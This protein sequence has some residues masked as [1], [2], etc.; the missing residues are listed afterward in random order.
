MNDGQ[1]VLLLHAAATWFMT[2]VIWF[3]QVVHYPLF[4]G[5]G[6]DRFGDYEGRHT[7]QTTWVVLPPMMVE[8]VT[9][10]WLVAAPPAGVALW[11]PITGLVLVALLW[12]STFLVQVPLHR[13]LEGGFDVAAHRRLVSLNWPRTAIWSAR[14]VLVGAMLG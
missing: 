1:L 10:V 13:R 4:A 6:V 9:A 3:V 7:R 8:L 2:G 12:V 14:A 11:M 5:V